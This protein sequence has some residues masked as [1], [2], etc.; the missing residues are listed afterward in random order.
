M[1][2]HIP[3]ERVVRA[4][5][6]R[7]PRFF[8]TLLPRKKRRRRF[9]EFRHSRREMAAGAQI[10]RRN[11]KLELGSSPVTPLGI[12]TDRVTRSHADPLRNGPILLLLLRQDFLNFQCLMR[13]HFELF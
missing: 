2:A 4:R 13:R 1:L 11:L 6:E 10:S 5:M 7:W 8:F 9:Q 3:K 12:V